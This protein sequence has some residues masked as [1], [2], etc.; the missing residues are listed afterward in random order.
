MGRK[1]KQDPTGQ[2][3]NRRLAGNR[4]RNRATL[5]EREVKALFRAI[6]RTRRQQATVVNQVIPVYD[7][8]ITAA[9][10]EV[11]EQRIRSITNDQFLETQFNR[12]PPNWWWQDVI[13]RPYRE[14]TAEEIVEFNRLVTDELVRTR[15]ARGL[16]TQRLEVGFVLQSPEYLAALDK[17]YVR[18]FNSIRTLSDRTADQVIQQINAGIEAGNT[19]TQI[20]KA[21]TER[22]DV[23]RSSATR[24]ANTEVNQAYNDARLDATDIAAQ[25]T[26]LRAGVLHLSALIPTTRETHAARHGNA[27]TTAQQKKWWNMSPNR[28][29]CHCSTRSVLIDAKGKVIDLELQEEIQAEREFFDADDEPAPTPAPAPRPRPRP[30]PKPLSESQQFMKSGITDPKYRDLLKRAGVPDI[31]P[32]EGGGA[33]FSPF[34]KGIHMGKLKP[35][36]VKGDATYR[37]EYGHFVDDSLGTITL[38]DE[39]DAAVLAEEKAIIDKDKAYYAANRDAA[40]LSKVRYSK[41]SVTQVWTLSKQ[42]AVR[43]LLDS[44]ESVLEWGRSNTKAGGIARM[45]I[46]KLEESTAADPRKIPAVAAVVAAERVDRPLGFISALWDDSGSFLL[47]DTWREAGQVTDLVGSITNNK[48]G[49]GHSNDYYKGFKRGKIRFGNN[50]EAWAQTFSLNA[51]DAGPLGKALVD[52]FAPGL[53]KILE[54]NL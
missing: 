8:Q 37:H 49:G 33:Y 18:N 34:S 52:E 6:P 4:L 12:M 26:G 53:V 13:E 15:T 24:I 3:R 47:R 36:T 28:I 32:P 5:A 27:Y 44:D 46:D 16:T 35:G 48:H 45:I 23:A 39:Y 29:N 2:A 41:R 7:Y 19:P 38:S 14:G 54:D 51:T 9:E 1:T 21:I 25:Q 20:A 40:G 11:L 42:A 10:L 22:F 30:K 50:L 43:D 31:I 17:V